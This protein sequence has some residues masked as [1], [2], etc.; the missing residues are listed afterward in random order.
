MEDRELTIKVKRFWEAHPVCADMIPHPAGSKT[1]FDEYEK[2]RLAVIPYDTKLEIYQF[3]AYAGKKV[4]DIGCGNGWVLS[5]YAKNGATCYGLDI[6]EKAIALS[7]K[8]I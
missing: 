2:L 5:H 4:L 8:K 1:F 7:K 3:T 6:T